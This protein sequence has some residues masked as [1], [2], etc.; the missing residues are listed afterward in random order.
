MHQHNDRNCKTEGIGGAHWGP[1]LAYMGKVEDAASA[2]GSGEFFKIYQNGWAKAPGSSQGDADFWGTKDLNYNCGKLDFKIPSDIAPGDYLLRA[3]AIALHAAGP[4]GGAQHYVTCYQLTVTGSG[5]ATPKGVKFPAAYS[6]TGPG[7]GFSIH[8]PLDSY[9]MPGPE[10]ISSGTEA[11]PQ[12]LTF[13]TITGS[14]ATGGG[15]SK[16]SS[17]KAA[18]PA[19]STAAAA[20]VTSAA[21]VTTPAGNGTAEPTTAVAAPTLTAP[22]VSDSFSST[23]APVPSTL[24]TSARPKPTE[25]GS[26]GSIQEWAQCG[27]SGFQGTGS[28]A[29]GLTCKEWNPYYSQ[30]IKSEGGSDAPSTTD[31][32]SAPSA[33]TPAASQP[34]VVEPTDDSE[35]TFTLNT[36][37][38]WLEE[39]ADSA[40]AKM[41]RRMIEAL[42]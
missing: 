40:S 37:I 23:L 29:S 11:T 34:T 17:T 28:C 31:V 16:P 42:Q 21:A 14:P 8:A 19:S 15:A 33:T 18:A 9:P 27:G 13:G 25:G 2:D 24:V 32:A 5:T 4:A 36:F 1:V 22:V 6:K 39:N 35:K 3:E 26:T 12:L 10:L 38:A 41:I 20:P 30:C 7:L